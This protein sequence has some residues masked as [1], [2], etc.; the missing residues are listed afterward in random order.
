MLTADAV[1]YEVTVRV[2]NFW[3]AHESGGNSGKPITRGVVYVTGET[4]S[5]QRLSGVNNKLKMGNGRCVS[6]V[7]GLTHVLQPAIKI[8]RMRTNEHS[9]VFC[10][11]WVCVDYS[12]KHKFY[13]NETPKCFTESGYGAAVI[14]PRCLTPNNLY[15]ERQR[16]NVNDTNAIAVVR[17]VDGTRTVVGFVPCELAGCLASAMESN[18]IKVV[19]TG[20]YSA[21]IVK[22][23]PRH[24]VW[25]RVDRRVDTLSTSTN[26][27]QTEKLLAIPWW[28]PDDL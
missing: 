18:M 27:T 7:R 4:G 1:S 3:S 11:M 14:A 16:D 23:A 2:D 25:F 12:T 8:R 5:M 26:V 6:G 15:L 24:R 28:V 10:S 22:G 21:T 9:T 20:V 19:G 17:N 13:C